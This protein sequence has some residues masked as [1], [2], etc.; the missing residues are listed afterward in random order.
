M[1]S[2]ENGVGSSALTIC[3]A[4]A[5]E[6]DTIYRIR[7]EIYAREL[8]QHRVNSSGNLQDSLDERNI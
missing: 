3:V 5:R 7:H 6:R 4:E 2:S 8:G 1:T